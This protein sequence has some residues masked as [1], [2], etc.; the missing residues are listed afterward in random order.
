MKPSL[1]WQDDLIE[2]EIPRGASVL[3]LGCNDGLLLGR[4]S[5]KKRARVQG[6]ELDTESVGRCVE[7]GVPVIH[8]DLDAGLGGFTDNSF[9]YVILEET[10][11]TLHRPIYVLGEMLRVGRRGIVSFPN[12]GYWRVRLQLAATGR[13]PVTDRLPYKWHDTPNIHL[14]TLD[15]FKSWARSG[16]IKVVKGYVLSNGLVREIGKDDNLIAEEALLVL[17]QKERK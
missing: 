2:K 10:L 7:R 5:A 16:G 17:E 9:D 4:L 3:D 11:Q 6:I 12:F 8:A 1:R 14:L 15:D 13:M